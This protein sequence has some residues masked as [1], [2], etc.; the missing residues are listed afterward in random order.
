M[1]RADELLVGMWMS[2][3]GASCEEGEVFGARL[4]G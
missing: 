3:R 2:M 4:V 1:H